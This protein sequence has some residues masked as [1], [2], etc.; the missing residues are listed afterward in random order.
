MRLS[1]LTEKISKS[2]KEKS[3]MTAA[4]AEAKTS[5]TP[6]QP[7]PQPIGVPCDLTVWLSSPNAELQHIATCEPCATH[8]DDDPP[9]LS[10]DKYEAFLKHCGSQRNAI[11][12]FKIASLCVCSGSTK[13]LPSKVDYPTMC[14]PMCETETPG[15]YKAFH[16]RV[17]NELIKMRS[18]V[19]R[20]PAALASRDIMCDFEVYVNEGANINSKVVFASI[21]VC[22]GRCGNI[23]E[24][25]GI[26][27]CAP[28]ARNIDDEPP[29]PK[30]N[31]DHIG[32]WLEPSRDVFIAPKGH[33]PEHLRS[34]IG[35]LSTFRNE[36]FIERLLSIGAETNISGKVTRNVFRI[37]CMRLE[38]KPVYRPSCPSL[39]VSEVVTN[40][41]AVFDIALGDRVVTAA[42]KVDDGV[43]WLGPAPSAPTARRSTD[44][45]VPV[46]DAPR[47]STMS[48][49]TSDPPN[50]HDMLVSMLGDEE[51][52][53]LEGLEAD[54]DVDDTDGPAGGGPDSSNVDND[55]ETES[56]SSR[57]ADSDIGDIDNDANWPP[58]PHDL[59]KIKV[60]AADIV[61]RDFLLD[62]LGFKVTP[63]WHLVDINN[64]TVLLGSIR[65]VDGSM[66]VAQCRQR[67]HK[68]CF[69]K[70]RWGK[71]HLRDVELPLLKWLI[72][73]VELSPE[74][75]K[76][77]AA[78]L[79]A[80]RKK[81][82]RV[83]R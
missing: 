3:R 81:E 45:P 55:T 68:E 71:I 60:W 32:L 25:L 53:V 34:D 35:S 66:L 69:C 43:D 75:H 15:R 27:E 14:G 10:L 46:T 19:A 47:H 72:S 76:H 8:K 9:H 1:K 67:A 74:A 58:G 73:G 29:A 7:Q 38:C 37:R 54:L 13:E 31:E 82:P 22:S 77:D 26:I 17:Y 61:D 4:K 18:Q 70:L 12:S 56:S 83:P 59:A 23:P 21:P 57:G 42:D 52:A 48:E 41:G 49:P 78:E 16:K 63:D 28:V 5:P 40:V 39:D 20:K 62:K 51:V 36:W 6:I 50:E 79:Q 33:C 24:R 64:E 44:D 65:N 2:N 80:A 30:V 11:A